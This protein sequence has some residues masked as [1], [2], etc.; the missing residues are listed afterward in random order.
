MKS[1]LLLTESLFFSLFCRAR[2][3]AFN[4]DRPGLS[5]APDVI[6]KGSWQI[7]QASSL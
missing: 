4:A 7:E 5:D 6:S 2:D 1:F 3:S